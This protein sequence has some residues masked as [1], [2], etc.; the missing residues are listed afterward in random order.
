MPCVGQ[1]EL[2]YLCW[3]TRGLWEKTCYEKKGKGRHW[4]SPASQINDRFFWCWLELNFQYL[5]SLLLFCVSCSHRVKLGCSS[6]VA[7]SSDKSSWASASV[8]SLRLPKEKSGMLYLTDSSIDTSKDL[9][10]WCQVQPETF[11]LKLWVSPSSIYKNSI[12]FAIEM[13]QQ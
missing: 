13:P 8:T 9:L 1:T 2:P 5:S 12:T 11:T 7:S 10:T 4:L 3:L 6:Q